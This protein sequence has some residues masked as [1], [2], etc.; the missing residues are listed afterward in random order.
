MKKVWI[1]L[2]ILIAVAIGAGVYWYLGQEDKTRTATTEE[3]TTVEL[4]EDGTIMMEAEE[5]E[6]ITED[7]HGSTITCCPCSI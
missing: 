5:V 6:E 4:E 1:I 2:L 3:S 7:T